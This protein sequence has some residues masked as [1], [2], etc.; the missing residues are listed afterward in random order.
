[1]DRNHRK[2][3]RRNEGAVTNTI[4]K[5]A[6]LDSR[7]DMHTSIM[8]NYIRTKLSFE[9]VKSQLLCIRG[10]WRMRKPYVDVGEVEVVQ[11]VAGFRE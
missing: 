1:M 5:V 6:L 10:L 7:P 3:R 8:A 2:S 4:D 11:H 9:I